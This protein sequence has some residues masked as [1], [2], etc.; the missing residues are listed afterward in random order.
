MNTNK[1]QWVLL[2]KNHLNIENHKMIIK[3]ILYYL[4]TRIRT[5]YLKQTFKNKKENY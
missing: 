4:N 3:Y 1:T 2:M 5:N